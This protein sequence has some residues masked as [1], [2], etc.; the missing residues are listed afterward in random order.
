MHACSCCKVGS[1]VYTKYSKVPRLY[2]SLPCLPIDRQLIKSENALLLHRAGLHSSA[3][4]Y[5]HSLVQ[6]TLL[7]TATVYTLRSTDCRRLEAVWCGAYPGGS[8]CLSRR[9][10]RSYSYPPTVPPPRAALPVSLP[11]PPAVTVDHRHRRRQEHR[12]PGLRDAHRHQGRQQTARAG[13]QQRS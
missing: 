7:Y 9:H 6:A 10:V 11:F 5:H 2:H 12:G 13:A 8:H 4:A 3:S 1:T